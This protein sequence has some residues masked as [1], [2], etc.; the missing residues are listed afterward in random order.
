MVVRSRTRPISISSSK[1]E[2]IFL[3][4]MFV[5]ADIPLRYANTRNLLVPVGPLPN[6]LPLEA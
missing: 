5:V 1:G 3:V 6:I 2:L 4:Q